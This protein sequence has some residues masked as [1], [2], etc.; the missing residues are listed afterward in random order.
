M[1]QEALTIHI[2]GMIEDGEHL[3]DPSKLEEIM[4]DP[5]FSDAAALFGR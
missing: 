4:S 2:Q 1:A 3:P 5:D